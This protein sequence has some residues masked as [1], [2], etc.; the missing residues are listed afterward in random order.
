LTIYFVKFET[1]YPDAHHYYCQPEPLVNHLNMFS[2][3][4]IS[5]SQQ[6]NQQVL[7]QQV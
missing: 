1:N 3:S 5:F 2:E 7:F 4:C 6:Q